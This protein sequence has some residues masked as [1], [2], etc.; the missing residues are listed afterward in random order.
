LLFSFAADLL[1]LEEGGFCEIA[2]LFACPDAEAG[3]LSGIDAGGVAAQSAEVTGANPA[4]AMLSLD[5]EAVHASA[6]LFSPSL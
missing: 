1:I 5:G 3:E 6:R 4:G 2:R